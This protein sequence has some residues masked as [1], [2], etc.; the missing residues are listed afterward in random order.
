MNHYWSMTRDCN[1]CEFITCNCTQPYPL[2]YFYHHCHSQLGS[3]F[4]FAVICLHGSSHFTVLGI[5]CSMLDMDEGMVDYL[6][7]PNPY[8]PIS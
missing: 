2:P 1:I 3:P 7:D 8:D 6:A 5:D 4:D